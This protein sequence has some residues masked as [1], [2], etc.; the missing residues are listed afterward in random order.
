MMLAETRQGRINTKSGIALAVAERGDPG[1]RPLVLLRGY[2]GI[3][4]RTDQERL[5]AALRGATLVVHE[6]AGHAPP[7]G[8]P[9]RVVADIAGFLARTP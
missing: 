4:T 5:M 6:G 3:C 8:G 9:K 7:L 2:T 1:G